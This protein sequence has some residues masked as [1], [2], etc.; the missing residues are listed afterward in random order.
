M[1]GH[2]SALFS[3]IFRHLLTFSAIVWHSFLFSTCLDHSSAF[4]D[5]FGHASALFF[6]HFS[7]FLDMFGHA[8]ALSLAFAGHFRP[9][10][11]CS[12]MLWPLFIDIVWPALG[13]FGHVVAFLDIFGHGSAMFQHFSALFGM[14]RQGRPCFGHFST[15]LVIFRPCVG[16]LVT[17]LDH[18]DNG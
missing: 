17:M 10:S 4:L 2:V 1:F 12:A 15:W 18:L 5:M 9:V 3:A 16:N 7:A 8:S 13:M 6:G 11:I 14:S